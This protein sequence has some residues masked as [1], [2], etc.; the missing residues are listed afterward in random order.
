MNTKSITLLGSTGTIGVNTLKVM[1]ANAERFSLHNITAY[2]NVHLL[3][4]Q[5]RTFKA[6]RAVIGNAAH[7][8]TLK[9]LL[10]HTNIEV[11]AGEEAVVEAAS[12]PCGVLMS[13]IVGAA[14]LKPTLAAIQRGTTVALANKECLVSAGALMNAEI[15]KSGA[16]ILPV[17]SEHNGI[18]Q[19]LASSNNYI[20]TITLTA[21]GGPFRNHTIE[22]LGNVTPAEA[23]KHPNW[24]MGAKISVDSATLMN[25]GLELIEAHYLFNVAPEK[26]SVLIHPQSIIH[27]LV[28]MI[29][30]SVLAQ[31]STPDM[32]IPIAHALAWPER[33]ASTA[34]PLK[35]AA[36]G[37]LEF[38]APDEVRFPALALAKAALIAGGNAP[39]ILNAANEVAVVRFLR[40]D[41]G[42]MEIVRVCEKALARP[43]NNTAQ[44]LEDV[45]EVDASTRRFA[46]MV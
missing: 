43:H 37:Q 30:G 25:K 20:E 8:E 6:K 34:K 13:A 45:L 46:E 15:Q 35:L 17:D 36:L 1:A 21:S 4:E 12:E 39:N 27:A 10:A 5:A 24:N 11:A 28:E 9:E 2:D 32:C 42:F 3:A 40:G 44:T 19:V 41:I 14:G 18:F 22:Q 16:K 33:M 38:F 23:V 26:L 7:Y 31:M 29:D